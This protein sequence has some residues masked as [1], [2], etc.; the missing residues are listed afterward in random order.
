MFM[1]LLV[2]AT[3]GA[4]GAVARFGLV[5]FAHRCISEHYPVGTALVNGLGSFLV[6]F[7]MMIIMERVASPEPYRL[8]LVVGFLGAFTTFSA[9]AWESLALYQNGQGW[10]ALVNILINNILSL[11]MVTVGVMTAR[12]FAA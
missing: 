11:A 5:S 10:A 6:G 3:G 12:R 9:Y 2:V 7:L 8:F 4:L 1:A